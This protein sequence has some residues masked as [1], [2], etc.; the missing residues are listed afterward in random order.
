MAIHEWTL[1]APDAEAGCRESVVTAE[2]VA[3]T[4]T[5]WRVALRVLSVGLSQGVALVEIDNGRLRFAVIPTRGMGLWRAWMGGQ[6]LGWRSP[7]RGPVHPAFVPI[8]EPSGLGW[9]SGF[10][11]L[12][13]RCGLESNGAPDFDERGRLT[14]PLH[15]RIANLPARELR[16]A[17]DDVAGTIS[18]HGIV[19]ESRFH[20]QK[21]R[22]HTTY[23]TQFG[24]ARIAWVDEV[25]NFGGATAEMQMLYHANIGQPQLEA[26]STLVAPIKSVGP[27]NADT[28][29]MGTDHWDLYSPPAANFRQQVYQLGLVAGDDGNTRVLLKNSCGAAGVQLSYNVRQLPCFSLWRNLVA[30][31]DGYVTGLEPGTNYPNPRSWETKQGRVVKLA[32]SQ[33]WT[34]QMALDWFLDPAAVA[35]SERGIRELQGGRQVTVHAGIVEG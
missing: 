11:E 18:L 5:G 35:D 33:R 12:M 26:G 13:C 31:E 24:S 17:V 6:E 32:P 1:F 25:E 21:L 34:A 23:T 2:D 27:A 20:Y 14:Y 30:G 3:G 15:G 7:V 16:L 4:S 10:D 28:V 8:A 9:L 29:A 19:E 22:L